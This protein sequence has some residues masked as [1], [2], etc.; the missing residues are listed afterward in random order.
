MIVDAWSQHPTPR[1]LVHPMFDS[2][3]RWT[4]AAFLGGNAARVFRL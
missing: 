1:H 4:R 3:R 2:L